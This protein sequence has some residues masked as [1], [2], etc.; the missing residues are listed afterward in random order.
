MDRF[1]SFVLWLLFL[2]VPVPNGVRYLAPK[3]VGFASVFGLVAHIRT[4]APF[5]VRIAS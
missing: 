5:S 1:G 2:M 4:L 3:G